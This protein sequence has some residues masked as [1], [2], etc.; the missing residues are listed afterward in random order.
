MALAVLLTVAQFA[1]LGL[2]VRAVRVTAGVVLREYKPCR[3]E[4]HRLF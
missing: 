1:A 4:T 3:N 2:E